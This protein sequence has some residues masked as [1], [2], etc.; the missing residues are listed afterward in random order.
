MAVYNILMVLV[1]LAAC[2]W[3]K[4]VSDYIETCWLLECPD[5]SCGCLD[6]VHMCEQ[7]GPAKIRT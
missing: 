5:V 2:E 3:P 1:V 4:Q 6:S 7:P